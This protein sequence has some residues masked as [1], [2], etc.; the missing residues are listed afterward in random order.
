MSLQKHRLGWIGLGRMGYPMAARLANA[1][2]DVRGYNRTRA[3]AEPLIEAGVRLVDR[4]SDL[5]A[6]DIVFT[7]VSTEDDLKSVTFGE[8]G[9]FS[10]AKSLAYLWTSRPFRLRPRRSFAR[11]RGRMAPRCWSFR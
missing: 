2:A 6:C 7:M 11:S 9:L 8:D 5:A 3:K 4:P 10:A 1:K